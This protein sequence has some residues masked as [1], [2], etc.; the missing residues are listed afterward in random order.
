MPAADQNIF[1]NTYQVIPRVLIFISDGKK[2][3]LIHGDE[4]KKIW[5]GKYNGVGGHL[6]PGEDVLSAARRELK[7]ETSLYDVELDLCGTVVVNVTPQSGVIL[8]VFFGEY[9]GMEISPSDEGSLEWVDVNNLSNLPVVE[10]LPAIVE[11]VI[12]WKNTGTLFF[13]HSGYDE[14][15]NLVIRFIQ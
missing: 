6:E 5:A 12:N 1:L 2:L 11:Q 9:N 15:G 8:H 14:V 13:G 10:D 3:L 4:N 7:E